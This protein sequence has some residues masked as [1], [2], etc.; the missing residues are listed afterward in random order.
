[1]AR[2]LHP[3]EI[4]KLFLVIREQLCDGDH[5]HPL[6]S[7]LKVEDIERYNKYLDEYAEMQSKKGK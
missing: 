3:I 4:A 6:R 5:P 2:L 7:V 1:M